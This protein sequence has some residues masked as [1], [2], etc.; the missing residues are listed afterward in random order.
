MCVFMA[1][2]LSGCTGVPNPATKIFDDGQRWT[3][4]ELD[5]FFDWDDKYYCYENG[6]SP[7]QAAFVKMGFP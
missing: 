3:A 2:Y 1:L 5:I 6:S 4:K 7:M